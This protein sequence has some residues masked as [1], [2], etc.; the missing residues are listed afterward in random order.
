MTLKEF[1][2]LRI[3]E[4]ICPK[5]CVVPGTRKYR[6]R[7]KIKA[8]EERITRVRLDILLNWYCPM[9]GHE[10]PLNTKDIRRIS[11]PARIIDG[12]RERSYYTEIQT[13][14]EE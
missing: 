9:C 1:R 12:V 10:E 7:M 8:I 4:R 5:R 11:K 13:T 2:D 3:G 6:Q 14:G